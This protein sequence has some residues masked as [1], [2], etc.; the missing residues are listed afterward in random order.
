M[1]FGDRASSFATNEV[2]IAPRQDDK[3]NVDVIFLVVHMSSRF[4]RRGEAKFLFCLKRIHTSF[5]KSARQGEG[6]GRGLKT[7]SRRLTLPRDY[8]R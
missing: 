1:N 5:D 8:F 4:I 7:E 2:R 3:R 6:R